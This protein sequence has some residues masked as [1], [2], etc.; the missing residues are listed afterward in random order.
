MLTLL[1]HVVLPWHC[2]DCRVVV[3]LQVESL[4]L[5]TDGACLAGRW[6]QTCNLWPSPP[7]ARCDDMCSRALSVCILDSV[8][9]HPDT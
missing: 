3:L 7:L 2:A 6:V 9:W 8:P 4:I 5:G 1:E